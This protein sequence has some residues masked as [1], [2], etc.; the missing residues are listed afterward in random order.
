MSLPKSPVQAMDEGKGN[1]SIWIT[2]KKATRFGKK[3]EKGSRI[4]KKALLLFPQAT[5]NEK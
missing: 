4:I 5:H 1:K 3:T 2:H